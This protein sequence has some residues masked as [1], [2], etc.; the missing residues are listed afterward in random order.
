M[1]TLK[2]LLVLVLLCAG[3]S[4]DKHPVPPGP[5]E[6]I[7]T[8]PIVYHVLYEDAGDPEQNPAY[9][10]F[11]EHVKSLNDFF[12][13]TL[14][15][16]ANSEVVDVDFKLATHAPD[17]SPLPEPGVHRVH[18]PGSTNM[19]SSEFMLS[20]HVED[21]QKSAIF[22]NP[23]QYINVWVFG[24]PPEENVGGRAFLPYTTVNHRLVG[25]QTGGDYYLNNLPAYMH[26][27]TICQRSFRT[28]HGIYV[29]MPHEMGHYLGLLHA[30]SESGSTSD[31]LDDYC[32]DTPAYDRAEYVQ[33]YRS[34]PE[35]EWYY[36]TS[37]SGKRFRSDNVMDYWYSDRTRFT[38]EQKAR[39]EHVLKYSPLIPRSAEASKALRD[40]FRSTPSGE[41]P[42]PVLMD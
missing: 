41:I 17:G 11:T 2:L 31:Y 39:M 20:K 26:G 23:N 9:W 8:L 40:S 13:A 15:P 19:Y 27:I 18:Y 3:C 42:E 7:A 14:H 34:L 28:E 10:Y 38:R 5:R 12:G 22:W 37:Y 21:A 33:K 25:T 32:A 35:T 4:K 36:R 1:K 29:A 24:T 6:V 16:E 30:F